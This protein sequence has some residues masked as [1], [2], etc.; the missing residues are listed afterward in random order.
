MEKIKLAIDIDAPKE[1]V[2]DVLLGDESYRKWTS[3]F[4][5]SSQVETDWKEGSKAIF[6]SDDGNGMI[7]RIA[8]HRPAEVIAIEHLGVVHDGKEVYD[9]PK[10][11]E[12]AGAMETYRISEHDGRSHLDIEMDCPP[13]DLEWMTAKWKEALQLVKQ[14]SEPDKQV[15]S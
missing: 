11:K 4:H 5:P 9:D 15:H 6:K 7:S 14:L 13:G 2:W 12:W 1:K 8:L 10:F 3:V